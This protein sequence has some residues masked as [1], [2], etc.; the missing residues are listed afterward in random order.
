MEK[1]VERRG[2]GERDWIG[3]GEYECDDGQEANRDSNGV[4]Y[5]LLPNLWLSQLLE[6]HNQVLA[7]ANQ[8]LM[9]FHATVCIYD[10]SEAKSEE[11]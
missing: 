10:H 11:I 9:M 2:N 8:S 4:S 7:K 1:E 6:R 3:K 5:G